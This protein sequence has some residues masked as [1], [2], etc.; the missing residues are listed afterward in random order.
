[1]SIEDAATPSGLTNFPELKGEYV[2]RLDEVAEK[3]ARPAEQKPSKRRFFRFL[4]AA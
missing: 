4:G 1:M 3:L 2:D